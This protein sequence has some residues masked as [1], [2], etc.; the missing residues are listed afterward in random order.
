MPDPLSRR[1]FLS[2]LAASGAA[3]GAGGLLAACGGGGAPR[4]ATAC[5]GYA[6]LSPGEIQTREGFQYVDATP[7]A[8][9]NCANCL[10]YVAP[11]ASG[12]G[13]ACGGCALFPGPVVENGYCI[14]WVAQPAA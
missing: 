11:E 14:G 9:K 4:T 7:D 10:S 1:R 13:P 12:D 2:R 3:L 6:A 8:T 5:E